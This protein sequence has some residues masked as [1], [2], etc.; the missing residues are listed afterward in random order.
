MNKDLHS[1]NNELKKYVN[2]ARAI[3]DKCRDK[4]LTLVEKH[5]YVKFKSTNYDNLNLT[6]LANG[7]IE[8]RDEI[9]ET[10]EKAQSF[11]IIKERFTNFQ[12]EAEALL[13]KK[14]TNF[15]KM[16]TNNEISNLLIVF[17]ILLVSLVIIIYGLKILLLGDI[18][19]LIWLIFMISYHIVPATGGRVRNRLIRAKRYLK[20]LFK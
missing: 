9:Y 13:N 16:K 19:G 17:L 10:S 15:D 4:L 6:I 20:S 3:S 1:L 8:M 18:Q 2:E 14:A 5:F 12:K 7:D 11:E